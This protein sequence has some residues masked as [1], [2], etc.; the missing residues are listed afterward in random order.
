MNNTDKTDFLILASDGMLG[1]AIFRYLQNKHFC[2]VGTSRKPCDSQ[3][4]FDISDEIDFASDLED[5]IKKLNPKTI[6]NCI[7]YIRPQGDDLSEINRSILLNSIFPRKLFIIAKKYQIRVI[8]FST[9]CVFDGL[10]GPYSEKD[11]PNEKS[12]YGLTKF[13]GEGGDGYSITIRT[14]I[15]GREIGTKRNLLDWF[16]A[17]K[18]GQVE[19]FSR[20]FWNGISTLTAA[21][22]VQRIFEQDLKFDSHLIQIAG[23]TLSKYDLLC[24]FNKVF[25]KGLEIIENNKIISN[26]TLIPSSTQDKF[27]AD[28]IVPI[29]DQ[30]CELKDF[31][32]M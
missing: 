5:I 23:E 2:V 12:I 22:I 26:K 18:G 3:I 9:D 21:K 24:M 27:F 7:G 10:N 20:V 6:V 29:C 8:H 17:E 13:L 11:I 25:D 1:N 32:E 16:L 19:G 28:L 30:I 15:I 4:L 14:S 31:Y